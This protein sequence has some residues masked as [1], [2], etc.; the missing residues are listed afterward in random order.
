MC[1]NLIPQRAQQYTFLQNAY[2][3]SRYNNSFDPDGDS[4]RILSKQV[5]KFNH[6]AERIYKQFI[7]GIEY[8]Q[9]KQY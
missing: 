4:V 9:P 5:T 8:S 6:T 1:F 2:S 3:Q 7:E